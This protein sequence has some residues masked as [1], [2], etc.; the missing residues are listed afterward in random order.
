MEGEEF[1]NLSCFFFFF[2]LNFNFMEGILL[3]RGNSI[4]VL[5]LNGT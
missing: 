4:M 1:R 3:V 5:S 2:F